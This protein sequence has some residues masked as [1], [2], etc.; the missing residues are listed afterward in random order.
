MRAHSLHCSKCNQKWFKNNANGH[1]ATK[2]A[3]ALLVRLGWLTNERTETNRIDSV[4]SA[5]HLTAVFT[6]FIV[7]REQYGA[8]LFF[9]GN[10]NT[11]LHSDSRCEQDSNTLWE[12]GL[13]RSKEINWGELS[14][15]QC[16]GRRCN[17]FAGNGLASWTLLHTTKTFTWMSFFCLLFLPIQKD[18]RSSFLFSGFLLWWRNDLSRI[19]R[20]TLSR[21]S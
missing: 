18:W 10:A 19:D 11:M 7:R 8:L 12:W 6:Q 21:F 20:N 1:G 4:L 9:W 14:K 2:F 15:E 13:A 3:S 17:Q 16:W 5:T